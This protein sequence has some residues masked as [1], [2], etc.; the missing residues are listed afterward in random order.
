MIGRQRTLGLEDHARSVLK[1][2]PDGPTGPD[3]IRDVRNA[4]HAVAA[5]LAVMPAPQPN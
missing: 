5:T 4:I 1:H 3:Q 2:L